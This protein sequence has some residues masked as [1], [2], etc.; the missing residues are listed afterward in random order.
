[1]NKQGE[2]WLIDYEHVMYKLVKIR[3]GGVIISMNFYIYIYIFYIQD[4]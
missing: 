4:L 2:L 1:M 3:C